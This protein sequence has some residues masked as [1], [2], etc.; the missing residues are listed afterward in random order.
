M[1]SIRYREVISLIVAVVVTA[2]STPSAKAQEFST[3]E[4]YER[5]RYIV[6]R[7]GVPRHEIDTL[8]W[9]HN[10]RISIAAPG[11]IQWNFLEGR[12]IEPML[13]EF[14][15]SS[16]ILA[17]HRYY[18]TPTYWTP[19]I[20]F[21]YSYY[22]NKWL[23]VGGK[24]SFWALYSDVRNIATDERLYRDNSYV[25]SAILNIRFDYL[26]REYVQLYS[27]IGAGLAARFKYNDGILTPMYDFTL[28]GISIGKDFYGFGEIGGGTSGALRL[29]F[30]WRF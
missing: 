29:G 17:K 16:D 5:T 9:R 1:K 25:A 23:S 30:G 12:S 10:L 21:E 19:P 2:L 6:V 8:R 27:A 24:A 14:R 13:S 7:E 22:V 20:S 4:A 28:F 11:I 3:E 26:R 18:Q 15:T